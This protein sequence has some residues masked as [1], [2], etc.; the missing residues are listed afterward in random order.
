MKTRR[1]SLLV[2]LAFGSAVGA[3]APVAPTNGGGDPVK[4]ASGA[5][6]VPPGTGIPVPRGWK[7]SFVQLLFADALVKCSYIGEADANGTNI[8][9]SDATGVDFLDLAEQDGDVYLEDV[10]DQMTNVRGGP[11]M[12]PAHPCPN[13]DYLHILNPI[14]HTF[15]SESNLQHWFLQ[16]ND[17][18]CNTVDANDSSATT[19][20]ELVPIDGSIPEQPQVVQ[21]SQPGQPLGPLPVD[22]GP[23]VAPFYEGN[24]EIANRIVHL[25][26]L[27]LCIARAL[28][29]ASPGTASANDTLFM[30]ASDER[31]LLEVTRERAQMAMIEFGQ[32]ANAFASV[33]PAGLA[34][35][36]FTSNDQPLWLLPLWAQNQGDS[37]RLKQMG[38]EFAESVQLDAIVS[39]ELAELLGRSSSSRQP[40]GANGANLAQETWGSGSW[41]QRELAMLF[42]GGP[43]TAEQ[44]GSSPWIPLA[45]MAP[46]ESVGLA[47]LSQPVLDSVH[48]PTAV[49]E[50]FYQVDMGQPEPLRLLAEARALDTQ[51]VIVKGPYPG[52]PD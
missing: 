43:L 10:I 26:S 47:N 50:P 45:G 16:R 27:N 12:D 15:F 11:T 19:A 30:T 2:L 48:W 3:C 14:T 37:A 32:L 38:A 4:T 36:S 44:D 6:T 7:G 40:R 23:A 29:T 31:E 5:L 17:T 25:P 42:G 46:T 8:Q 41:R 18:N 49:E 24:V 13:G 51:D 39:R 21:A 1:A 28:R 9:G 22:P 20:I 34:P 35:Q 52:A 33:P